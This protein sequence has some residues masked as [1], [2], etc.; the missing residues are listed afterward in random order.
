MISLG[1]LLSTT[2]HEFNNILMTINGYADLG[3]RNADETVRVGALQKIRAAGERAAEVTQN[4]LG[5]ARNRSDTKEPTDL[6][7]IVNASLLLLRREMNKYSVSLECDFAENLP[8]VLINGT[9]IQEILI[10]LLINAR[11]AMDKGGV[12]NLQLAYDETQKMVAVRVR[13]NGKGM[14]QEVLKHIFEPFFSTKKG[15]D[16]SGKGGTGLGLSRCLDI[17]KEHGGKVSVASTEG[18]GTAF[19][20][21]LP[22]APTEMTKKAAPKKTTVKK[23]T[24]RAA[25]KLEDA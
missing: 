4:I 19:T 20:L 24:R 1:E 18:K 15:P 8:K 17:V 7:K 9:Q 3:L 2:T 23:V 6:V 25:K 21:W 10:N 12:V 13:D 5:M 22:V 16:E 11:Q 14:S